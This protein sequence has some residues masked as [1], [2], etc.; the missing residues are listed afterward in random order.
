MIKN[1]ATNVYLSNRTIK[2]ILIDYQYQLLQTFLVNFANTVFVKFFSLYFISFDDYKSS[3]EVWND[4]IWEFV[5]Q[6]VSIRCLGG[7]LCL[8]I[9][10]HHR[11]LLFHGTNSTNLRMVLLHGQIVRFQRVQIQI[12]FRNHFPAGIVQFKITIFKAT[13]KIILYKYI[14]IRLEHWVSMNLC[15]FPMNS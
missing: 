15:C 6:N 2:W 13:A 9:T 14:N 1:L 4:N 12:R 5:W 8:V 7:V 10:G 3:T 11:F